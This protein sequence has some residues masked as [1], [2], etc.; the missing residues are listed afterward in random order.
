MHGRP[1]A[2]YAESENT[3]HTGRWQTRRPFNCIRA[4]DMAVSIK[5]STSASSSSPAGP[6]AADRPATMAWRY[7]DRPY[8]AYGPSLSDD[9]PPPA[10]H[11]AEA[12]RPGPLDPPPGFAYQTFLNG[13]ALAELNVNARPYLARITEWLPLELGPHSRPGGTRRGHF[14]EAERERERQMEWGLVRDPR[15]EWSDFPRTVGWEAR[16]RWRKEREQVVWHAGGG[17]VEAMDRDQGEFLLSG[18]CRLLTRYRDFRRTATGA[19]CNEWYRAR[20]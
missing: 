9:Y 6:Q 14:K 1:F 3:A 15:F 20:G 11:P 4:P 18:S 8:A 2:A 13:F 12:P 17:N 10:P 19:R 7:L 16:R 5:K